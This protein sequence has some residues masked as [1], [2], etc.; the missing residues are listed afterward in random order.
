MSAL[1][2]PRFRA[3]ILPGMAIYADAGAAAGAADPTGTEI[4]AMVA[5]INSTF[6]AFKAQNDAALTELRKGRDDVVSREHVDRVNAE[7][8]KLTGELE[9]VQRRVAAMAVAGGSNDNG[10][11]TAERR[12]HAKAFRAFIRKGIDAG[13][14]DLE[15]KAALSTDSNPDGG[16]TVTPATEGVMT[17]VLETVSAMRRLAT[18][19]HVGGGGFTK[20]HN[21]AGTG[22]GWVGETSARPGTTTPSL[23]QV[24]IYDGEIY[25]MPAATQTM[26]DDSMLD[27]ETWLG[28]EV[29]TAFAEQE[30]SAFVSGNGVN[31]PRGILGYTTVANASYAWGKIGFIKTGA[32]GGFVVSSATANGYDAIV[33]LYHSLKS[34]YR[35]NASFLMNDASVA[36]IRKIKDAEGHYIYLPP[37]ATEPGSVLGKPVETDDNMPD[38][39]TDQF[40]IAFGDFARGY[41]ITD[42]V[43]VRVLRDPYSS[44]PYVLFYTTKRVGGGVTDFAAIKLL[45][46]SA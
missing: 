10:E 44:K 33:D 29:V 36:A 3:D 21:N 42:R 2:K 11:R 41:T 12:E 18:V 37:T 40:P 16:F 14:R 39:A 17:R 15:V 22:T 9:A 46:A 23:E 31:K 25:A 1:R 8:G 6:E 26:L 43:G 13:L 5:K 28:T 45:K 32:N 30:G 38:F 20:L 27:V 19:V 35:S 4:A 7:V 24:K 34:G